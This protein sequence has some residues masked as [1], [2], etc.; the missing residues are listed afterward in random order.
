[1]LTG[2]EPRRSLEDAKRDQD[3]A[4]G[5]RE[6]R[7]LKIANGKIVRASID[8]KRLGGHDALGTVYWAYLRYSSR[9]LTCSE[10]VG[11]VEEATRMDRL[12]RAWE[13]ARKKGL[14]RKRK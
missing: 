8:L 4:A 14:L 7:L 3:V 10:Y 12:R 2:K 13:L 11:R 9:G 1:M 6:K 5:G